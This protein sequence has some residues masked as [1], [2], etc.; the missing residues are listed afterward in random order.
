MAAESP[1]RHA[2]E[3]PTA[4]LAEAPARRLVAAA[5]LAPRIVL[6]LSL[7]L[8]FA[9]I[10]AIVLINVDRSD[11][12]GAL[13]GLTF[14]NLTLCGPIVLWLQRAGRP[15][16]AFVARG[17]PAELVVAGR[18]EV[19]ARGRYGPMQLKELTLAADDGATAALTLRAG[20]DTPAIGARV[21]A[22][23]DPERRA[24]YGLLARDL[25]AVVVEL[26]RR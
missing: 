23:R 24:R 8:V 20:A 15:A 11:L 25:P 4:R 5:T 17:V 1:F 10:A 14:T 3:A 18:R 9:P 19:T 7:A 12:P 13:L 16:R 26:A 21:P 22:L 6:A 2:A